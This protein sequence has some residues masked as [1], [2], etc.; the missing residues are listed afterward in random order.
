MD[1]TIYKVCKYCRCSFTHKK[2]RGYW[3]FMTKT[4]FCSHSCATSYNNKHRIIKESTREKASQRGKLYVGD[5]NPNY[6]GGGMIFICENCHGSFEIP[7]GQLRG[8]KY[9]GKFCSLDCYHQMRL[10]NR[11][12]STKKKIDKEFQRLLVRHAK[13]NTKISKSRWFSIVGY[14][15]YDFRQHME[16][17]FIDGMSWDNYGLWHIDHIKPSSYFQYDSEFNPLFKECWSLSNLQPLWAID[18]WHKG[19]RNT[20]IN[21]IENG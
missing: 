12:P 19:G 11:I 3:Q 7:I 21:K 1:N 17:L 5:K 18:N 20:Y 8:K 15:G 4:V 10:I 13:G 9:I 6:K 2:G 16:S 14:T